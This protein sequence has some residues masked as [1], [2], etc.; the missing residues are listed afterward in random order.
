[1]RSPDRGRANAWCGLLLGLLLLGMAGCKK[2][3]AVEPAAKPP[4]QPGAAVTAPAPVVDSSDPLVR[5]RQEGMARLEKALA[6]APPFDRLGRLE[7]MLLEQHKVNLRQLFPEGYSPEKLGTMAQALEELKSRALAATAAKFTPQLLAETQ[8]LAEVEF[9]LYKVGDT[10]KITT[11][12]GLPRTGKITKTTPTAVFLDGREVLLRDLSEPKRG[13]FVPEECEKLRDHYARVN[14]KVP[15]ED[16]YKARM[17][18]M[19]SG[20]LRDK[21]FVWHNDAWVRMDEFIRQTVQGP[22]DREEQAYKAAVR[23]QLVSQIEVALRQEKLLPDDVPLEPPPPPPPPAP[24]K[25]K[26]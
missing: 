26:K 7:A 9:P 12:N 17:K 19:R 3:E 23:A 5:A 10:V 18:D 25:K 4:A 11:Y 16:F 14:F 8:R 20:V 6:E 2:E 21:G 22:L 13:C 24:T 1:M 15:S